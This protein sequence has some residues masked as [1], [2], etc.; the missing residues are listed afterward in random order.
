MLHRCSICKKDIVSGA[1]CFSTKEKNKP[2][3][4]FCDNC[5]KKNLKKINKNFD[6]INLELKNLKID[7]TNFNV[8]EKKY[9]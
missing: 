1:Y 6:K 4:W 2:R 9:K 3:Q 7:F 5:V 8:G